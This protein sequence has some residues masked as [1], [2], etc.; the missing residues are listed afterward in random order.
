M[1]IRIVA[2]GIWLRRP[3]G[4]TRQV[5]HELELSADR[6][7]AR[8]GRGR[9]G[10]VPAACGRADRRPGATSRA[11]ARSG[12]GQPG[13]GRVRGGASGSW[14]SRR[15][16]R[17]TSSGGPA[18]DLLRAEIVF[19][20]HRG[21]DAPAAAA[22]GGAEARAA[23][24][25]PRS[26]HVSRCVGCGAVRRSPGQR[27][28]QAA[29]RLA[30]R[31][32][33]ARSAEG[34]ASTRPAARRP[35]ADLHRGDACRGARCCGARSPRSRAARPPRRRCSDGVGWRHGRRSGCG[36]TTAASRSRGAPSSSRGTP[37]RSR[38]S[39]SRTTCAV[40]PPRG[41]ATSSSPTLL[42]AEVE[43]VKEATGSRIGPYAAI[44]LVGLRGR[45]AEAVRADRRRHRRTPPPGGQGTAVQYAHW[46][47]AV[48]MNGLGRYEEALAAALQ[49]TARDAGAVRRR[50]GA[51]R[52]DRGGHEDRE[53]RARAAG[54]RAPRRADR[55]ER[56]RLGARHRTPNRARC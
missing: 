36:T 33:G 5:A 7:Q 28:R 10:C 17:S 19:A 54:A 47:N 53:R 40:R 45:E 46:A 35:G 21:G 52:A 24:R 20:Q 41:A 38:S 15:P 31:G 49:A 11:G 13:R 29:R 44:S 23:R 8:G 25:P 55:R 51:G 9:R 4:R 48:L 12:P 30:C 43:A 39:P 22:P 34:G 32:G 56:R 14:R 6:A 2:H 18:L 37:G 50:V 3:S 42:V 1:S 26:Q 27:R 16:G